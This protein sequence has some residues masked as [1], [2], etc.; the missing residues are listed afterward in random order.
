MMDIIIATKQ[1]YE[2]THGYINFE[3]YILLEYIN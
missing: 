2:Y 1:I 3:M